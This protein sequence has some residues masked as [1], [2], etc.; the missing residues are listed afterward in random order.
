MVP[1]LLFD[2]SGIDLNRVQF[3]VEV[4]EKVNPHR[5]VMRLLD[6]IIHASADLCETVAYHDIRADA[7]WTAGHIPGRPIF[8]GVLQLEAAA[9]LSSWMTLTK[10]RTVTFLGFVAVDGAKFR[11]QVVPGDRLIILA[12]QLELRTRRSIYACQGLVNGRQVFEATIT[13]MSI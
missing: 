10:L 7:F 3:D 9:Q 2:I 12:K 1:S 8:P 13:G 5:G 4:I 6:G 11:G